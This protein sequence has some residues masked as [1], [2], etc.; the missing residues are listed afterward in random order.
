MLSTV[1]TAIPS[2]QLRRELVGRIYERDTDAT[3]DALIERL[4]A[5]MTLANLTFDLE[6]A[7][8]LGFED[9]A[10][11][12]ANNPFAFGVTLMSP[13]QL[14]YVFSLTRR[15]SVRKAIEIGRYKGGSAL[16]IAAAMGPLGTLW[17][18]D[19]GSVLPV[20]Q[21]VG[22]YENQLRVVCTRFDLDVRIIVA[23]S[24]TV[25]LD[26][27]L[28]DL[29]LID[30]D[31][32]FA[33][34]SADFERWARRLRLGGHVLLDD[35]FAVGPYSRHSLAVGKVVEDALDSKDFKLVQVV[36][37]MAHLQRVR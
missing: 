26:T 3:I 27:G 36:D 6:P 14:A 5:P 22:A 20:G 10:V 4:H 1:I 24:R 28:V 34:S 16:T 9:L 2:H 25:E 23:D 29:V 33:S 21:P 37:R 18:V 13:R 30:G 11:L 8:M 19:D 32:S 15:D 7:G 17:S 12:Y 35:A 31:H